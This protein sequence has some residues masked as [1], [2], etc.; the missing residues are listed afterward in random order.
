M[1]VG[2]LERGEDVYWDAVRLLP[3]KVSEIYM[4]TVAVWRR[5]K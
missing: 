5:P 2:I 4:L 3:S 1:V